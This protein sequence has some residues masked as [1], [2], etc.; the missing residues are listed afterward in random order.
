MYKKFKK[1]NTLEEIF[2]KNRALFENVT[3]FNNPLIFS[4]RKNIYNPEDYSLDF[5]KVRLKEL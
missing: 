3:A 4:T 2:F 1:M 5:L